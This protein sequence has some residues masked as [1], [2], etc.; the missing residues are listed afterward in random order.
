MR[1][2]ESDAEAQYAH[3]YSQTYPNA[4][5]GFHNTFANDKIVSNTPYAFTYNPFYNTWAN[6]HNAYTPYT[7]MYS[8]YPYTTY[9]YGGVYQY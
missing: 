8:G 6:N 2:A 7:N 9:N 1:E 3:F 4:Y 5:T